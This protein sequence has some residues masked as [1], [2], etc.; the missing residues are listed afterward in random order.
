M[1]VPLTDRMNGYGAYFKERWDARES[2]ISVEQDVVPI[3][4]LI[5]GMIACESEICFASYIY[6]GQPERLERGTYLGCVKITERFMDRTP[7]LFDAQPLDWHKPEALI[8]NALQVNPPCYH[9]SALHL[10]VDSRWPIA[11][12]NRYGN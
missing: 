10:H 1:L 8:W 11:E 7:D 3:G 5:A 2:F 9:D 12:I 4:G 6:P